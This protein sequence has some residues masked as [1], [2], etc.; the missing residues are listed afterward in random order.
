MLIAEIRCPM[1][2][3]RVGAIRLLADSNRLD[4]IQYLVG[5]FE[6]YHDAVGDETGKSL[7][8]L[9]EVADKRRAEGEL[10]L[11]DVHEAM[12]ILSA[13]LFQSRK[14]S[15][16]RSVE[17]FIRM[18]VL[19]EDHFWKLYRDLEL[20]QYTLLH[21]EFVR[22]RRDGGLYPMYRGLLQ[23][24]E[25]V[26]ER[27]TQFIG[28]AVRMS[29]EDV[30]YHLQALRS[31]DKEDF[32]R[33]A[34]VMQHYRVLVE[35]QGLIKFMNPPER[36]VLFD[37]LEA[38][39]AEQNLAFLHRCLELDDTRIRIR[40]LKIL[41]ESE[42]LP[43]QREVFVFLTD[44]DEQL[45]LATLRYIRKKGDL[46][47]LDRIQ[48]LLRSKKPK[49]RRGVITTIYVIMRDNLLKDF[50]RISS[51]KRE[52]ILS[53]LTKMKPDFFEEIS[54]L[55]TSEEVSDRIMY[56]KMLPMH[57]FTETIS[58][59]KRMSLDREPKVRS[60]AVSAFSRIEADED[61]CEVIEPFLTD[62]DARV[63]ANA[64]ELLP[65][66]PSNGYEKILRK[67]VGS[68]VNREKANAIQKLLVWGNDDIEPDLVEMLDSEDEWVKASGLWVVGNT[69]TP[70]FVNRLRQGANDLRAPV[71]EMAVRGLGKKGSEE[72]IRALMPFLQDPERKVRVVAQQAL[73]GR[74]N[75]NFEIG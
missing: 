13:P 14:S 31:L 72:D 71:R 21:E 63:R 35:Y 25:Q 59:L 5:G 30:N 17:Y 56:I 73:R 40:V 75:L 4:V 54:Y 7:R 67:A 38:V 48:H 27:L 45:L 69:E 36:I 33:I 32:Q 9:V 49:V 57:T 64:I 74:L 26:L 70:Q 58:E 47:V 22:L 3:V 12:G 44:T 24:S 42:A 53:Q 37:L 52:K 46:K 43:L 15:K 62:S 20:A 11:Q 2:Q 23:M 65:D 66:Y 1:W 41:S 16:F 6:D 19:D 28:M 8:K 39:G 18:A 60:C 55:S 68:T 34:V 61:R 50:N 51:T 29:G 10:D